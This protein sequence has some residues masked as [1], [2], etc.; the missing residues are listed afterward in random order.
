MKTLTKIKLINWHGF[1]N[2]T[3]NIKGSVLVTGENGTGKSTLLDAIYYV[4][5][6]GEENFNSAA[7]TNNSRTVETYMRGKTGIEGSAYLRQEPNLISHI[8]LEYYDD[9]K[10]EYFV[11][12]VVLEIQEGKNKYNSSFYHIVR[13]KLEECFY[14]SDGEYLNFQSMKRALKDLEIIELNTGGKR[15]IRKALYRILEMENS[16]DRYYQLLPKAIAFKPIGDHGKDVNDFV[17][18]FLMPEKNTDLEDIKATINSYNEIRKSLEAEKAKKDALV[19]ISNLGNEYEKLE[20]EITCLNTIKDLSDKD[21]LSALIEQLESDKIKKETEREENKK[22]IELY[23][24]E[25]QSIKDNK[26]KLLNSDEYRALKETEKEL[27]SIESDLKNAKDKKGRFNKLITEETNNVSNFIGTDISLVKYIKSEKYPE[28]RADLDKYERYIENKRTEVF[29]EENRINSE[30][31]RLNDRLT[32]LTDKKKKLENGLFDYSKEITNLIQLIQSEGKNKRNI[33]ISVT[34]LCELLEIKPEFEKYRNSI[35]GYLANHR[36]DLFVTESNFN[37]AL[38]VYVRNKESKN[39]ASVG[40]VNSALIPDAEVLEGSLALMLEATDSRA[41]KYINY[42][43][44][45]V[46]YTGKDFF[47]KNTN[48]SVDEKVFVYSNYAFRQRKTDL[49]SKPYIGKKSIQM[50][51]EKVNEELAK[52][53]V[54]LDSLN[55][56]ELKNNEIRNKIKNTKLYELK[57]FGNV[58][59]EFNNLEIKLQLKQREYD[60]I[61]TN[62]GLTQDLAYFDSEINRVENLINDLSFKNEFLSKKLGKIESDISEN[63]TKFEDL[64]LKLND[65]DNYIA[66]HKFNLS[67]LIDEIEKVGK[68]KTLKHRKLCSAMSAFIKDFNYDATDDIDSLPVFNNELNQIVNRNLV[69]YEDK[70][71]NAQKQATLTFQNDYIEKIRDNIK[72]EKENIDALNKVLKSRPFGSDEE[73]YQ[74]IISKSKDDRF[75]QYYDILT[76]NQNFYSTNLF[77]ETLSDKNANLMQ[78]LFERLTSSSKQENHEKLVREYTDYRKFMSYDIRIT[79]KHGKDAYFSKIYKEK[80]GGETQTP[81]YVVI[82]ASF[83][84]IVKGGYSRRSPGCLVMF[85]E[86]FNNMDESRIQSMMVYFNQL[87]IQPI[88]AV[89]TTRFKSI[90]PHVGTSIILAKTGG[91]IVNA[92][93]WKNDRTPEESN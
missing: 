87:S 55:K 49:F 40:L 44:G 43:L 66:T 90:F 36:F 81:F 3:I 2:E 86:A 62:Q 65:F 61:A 23:G 76:S 52:V 74:F 80:S 70:L 31:N 92:A 5:T 54:N 4:L 20:K 89:P 14:I 8:A 51:L 28:F 33:D 34:P 75:G 13:S 12:G 64:V 15:G 71:E 25:L 22:K 41:L 88:I 47:V 46:I 19:I 59:E 58:W 6:G 7:N 32:S 79:N 29:K 17:Y 69:A 24:V 10:K 1:Y 11:I 53:V 56:E 39:I 26:S 68:E 30:K 83:D 27:K 38:D 45:N 93:E 21:R 50:Q 78:E 57:N 84:Q 72:R 63:K 91:R 42:L 48:K 67:E 73:V 60:S 9:I 16:N 35:E 37:F 82:A 85:D 18:D 77:V